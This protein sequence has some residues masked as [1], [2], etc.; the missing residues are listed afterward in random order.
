MKRL[1]LIALIAVAAC[2]SAPG[3]AVRQPGESELEYVQRQVRTEAGFVCAGESLC[4]EEQLAARER[5]RAIR[6]AAEPA[7]GRSIDVVG[8]P[9]IILASGGG[10]PRFLVIQE[11]L[12]AA[13]ADTQIRAGRQLYPDWI[14]AEV[15]LHELLETSS[16]ALD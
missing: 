6:V 8:G 1:S 10:N 4:V 13:L 5:F 2:V 11:A 12:T 16:V 15:R 7:P 14:G 9:R 3:V